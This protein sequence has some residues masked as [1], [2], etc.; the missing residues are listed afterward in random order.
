MKQDKSG[1]RDVADLLAKRAFMQKYHFF[2]K[3]NIDEFLQI[4]HTYAFAEG[5][6]GGY[7]E[8]PFS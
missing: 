6:I 7:K 4:S 1:G 5:N 3:W 8:I 2:H